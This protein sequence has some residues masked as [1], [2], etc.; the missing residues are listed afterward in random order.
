LKMKHPS[1]E[2]KSI[3]PGTVDTNRCKHWNMES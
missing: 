1:T 2:M 3:R